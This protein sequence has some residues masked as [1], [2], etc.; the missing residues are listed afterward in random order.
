MKVGNR[1]KNG[2]REDRINARFER[3]VAKVNKLEA[4]NRRLKEVLMNAGIDEW[5]VPDPL[6]QKRFDDIMD[7]AK[8]N[9][10]IA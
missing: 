8:K 1:M 3:M 10:G 6:L 5:H 2:R 9:Q 4:E 7:K